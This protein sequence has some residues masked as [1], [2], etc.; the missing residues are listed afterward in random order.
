MNPNIH[1]VWHPAGSAPEPA[2]SA[3]PHATEQAAVWQVLG[4]QVSLQTGRPGD[5]SAGS[6]LPGR[7]VVH[8][9]EAG[10][11]VDIVAPSWDEARAAALPVLLGLV[12]LTCGMTYLRCGVALAPGRPDE[13]VLVLGA[14]HTVRSPGPCQA[15]EGP[16]VL[17]DTA[18]RPPRAHVIDEQTLGASRAGTLRPVALRGIVVATSDDEPRYLAPK[19]ARSHLRAHAGLQGLLLADSMTGSGGS[20]LLSDVEQATDRHAQELAAA[21]AATLVPSTALRAWAAD[22]TATDLPGALPQAPAAYSDA[23]LATLREMQQLACGVYGRLEPERA[24]AWALEELGELAQAIRRKEHDA[25]IT[26]ELGQLFSWVLCLANI[27]EVDLADAADRSL[28]HEALRQST[29]YGALRPYLSA[30]SFRS[31]S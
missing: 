29:Q 19:A 1:M 14:E 4:V 6:G 9:Q 22:P 21:L 5:R 7:L 18:C 24:L 31:P 23:H 2:C 28:Q 17:V 12:A 15:V 20:H 10:L 3:A 27:C 25:R 11:G 8:R 13:G 30:P 16:H 26:E